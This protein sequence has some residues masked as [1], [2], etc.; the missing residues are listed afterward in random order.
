MA[1]RKTRSN[2]HSHKATPIA[3]YMVTVGHEP[4]SECDACAQPRPVL[5]ENEMGAFICQFC[6]GDVN[7]NALWQMAVVNGL[8]SFDGG[9]WL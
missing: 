1:R 8:Y 5:V 9:D 4:G 6:S 7:N 3:T 2:R